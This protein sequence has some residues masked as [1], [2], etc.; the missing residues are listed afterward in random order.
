MTMSL[1]FILPAV[2]YIYI[3]TAPTSLSSVMR[4]FYCTYVILQSK[5]ISIYIEYYIRFR[6]K[7]TTYITSHKD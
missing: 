6:I 3:S 7:T 5:I 1:K 2:I 4:F